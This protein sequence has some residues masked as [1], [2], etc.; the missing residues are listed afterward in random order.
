MK[1]ELYFS[2]GLEDTFSAFEHYFIYRLKKPRMRLER[3]MLIVSV[4]VDVGNKTVGALNKGKNDVNVNDYFNEYVVG[5]IEEQALPL[6]MDFFNL[7]DVPVTFGIRGQLLEVDTSVLEHLLESLVQ[8]DIGSHSYYHR[9]FAR[10]S[11]NEAE[12]ELKLV[13]TAMRALKITPKSFIFPRGGVAHLELL[14]KFGYQCYRGY[15][16]FMNDG[17][18]IKKH[19]KLYDIHPGLYIGNSMNAFLIKKII[20]LAIKNRLPFHVWF[21]PWN[22]GKEKKS[23]NKKINKLFF[24]IFQY[25]KSKEKKSLLKFE[26][27][28]SAA[29]KMESGQSVFSN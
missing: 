17:M 14:E 21:H 19:G 10:L 13:S 22:L 11:Y 29:E 6:I 3:A 28:L 8:H 7:F 4:D 24:P 23:I 16:D 27:M 25:A 12:N 20:D 1:K 9:N 26:T 18:Y 15:G 2:R 5:E